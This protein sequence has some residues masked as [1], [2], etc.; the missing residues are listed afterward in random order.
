MVVYSPRHP[1]TEEER[2]GIFAGESGGDYDAL[3]G[4]SNRN[5]PFAG[6]RVS[7]MTLGELRDF[8]QSEYGPW[9]EQQLG[10]RA[11]P[12]GA[13]QIVGSTRDA[14]Q[15]ALGLSDDTVYDRATQDLM[16]QWIRDNQ[17]LG[18]WEG[19]KGP[20]DPSE[21]GGGTMGG[22]GGVTVSSRNVGGA[23]SGFTG[24]GTGGAGVLTPDVLAMLIGDSGDLDIARLAEIA[25]LMGAEP[26]RRTWGDRLIGG[27][28]AAQEA[29]AAEGRG[30]SSD[31]S[32]TNAYL[33]AEEE[34]RLKAGLKGVV[35]GSGGLLQQAAGARKEK[36]NETIAWLESLGPEGKL[37]ADAVRLNNMTPGEAAAKAAQ[38]DPSKAATKMTREQLLT[39]L[40]G[41]PGAEQLVAALNAGTPVE[42]VWKEAVKMGFLSP[43]GTAAALSD[44]K[45]KEAATYRQAFG[46]KSKIFD[47]ID[48]AYTTMQQEAQL[49]HGP[50]DIALATAFMKMLDPTSVV[51]ES[52]LA[53]A[54]NS[55]GFLDSLMQKI[56]NEVEKTGL[57]TKDTRIQLIDVAEKLYNFE[58]DRVEKEHRFYANIAGKQQIPLYFIAPEL[59]ERRGRIG[60]V[61]ETAV[62]ADADDPAVAAAAGADF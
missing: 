30:T 36:E 35:G 12:A 15:K 54:M 33:K 24:L 51:R 28:T 7:Q 20:R 8:N 39:F 50:G 47:V 4:F 43:A 37:L 29:L 44:E 32:A 60:E 62:A 55:G 58:R 46:E 17:G 25:E 56:K 49:G 53:M 31:F 48:R 19:Y 61:A 34:R 41:K 6:T 18:A 38:I 45:Q 59:G 11:T 5:G 23:D 26:T 10:Y 3:F 1:L 16:A 22:G 9:T 14:A 40:V 52:E 13:Y 42:D 2:A 57:L 21:V 27:L